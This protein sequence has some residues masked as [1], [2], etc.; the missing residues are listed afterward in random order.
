MK[1]KEKVLAL[2]PARLKSQRLPKKVIL[3]IEK[4]PIIIH[5]Y[6]RVLMSKKIDD[7]II[8]CDDKKIYDLAKKFGAKV[9]LTSKIHK[10]GTERICEAYRKMKKKYDLIVDVQGDEPLIDSNHINKVIDF[11]A[12]NKSTDIIVPN[13]LVKNKTNKNIV[14][15]IFNSSNEV[16]YMSRSQIPFG[17]NKKQKFVNKHLSIVSF[18]SKALLNYVKFKRTK[19][20]KI[21]NIELLRA[22][23]I[24]MKVKTFNLKG[25]SFSVDVISDY[26]KAKNYMKKDNLFKIYR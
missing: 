11:H 24:G 25:D 4:I 22:L 8:C 20:E 13:L 3:L 9:M 1:K 16:L 15:L 17:Q 23:E 19:L 7:V 21:E 6:R 26:K 5:V 14:K 10:N 12:K 2:I 18:K